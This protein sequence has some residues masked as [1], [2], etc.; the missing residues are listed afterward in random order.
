[1]STLIAVYD[2]GGLV[3]RCDAKCYQAHEA[4]CHCVCGGNN[5]GAGLDQA[6]ANTQTYARAWVEQARRSG[7]RIDRAELG[8]TVVQSALFDGPSPDRPRIPSRHQ[9]RAHAQQLRA[10]VRIEEEHR[11]EQ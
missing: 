3:G 6:L 7:S 11:R 4:A 1:M 2:S 8:M 9:T 10:V 5:H